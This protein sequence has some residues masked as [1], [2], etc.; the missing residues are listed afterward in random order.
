[1]NK[2][3]FL[4]AIH[5]FLVGIKSGALTAYGVLRLKKLQQPIIAVFGGAGAYDDGK[6]SRLAQEFGKKCAEKDMSII[7]GGGPG[8]M[9]AANCGAHSARGKNHTLG[10]AV[11]GVDDGFDNEC[12]PIVK[13]DYFFSRKWLLTRYSQAFVLFPGGI[14]TLDEFAEV[15]N[16][17]KLK[18]MD[19][20]PIIFFGTSYWKSLIDWYQHAFDY[21]FI[22]LPPQNAFIVVDDVDEALAVII[23]SIKE[24]T[25]NA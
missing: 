8:I 23:N 18:K 15:L 25:K 24:R 22:E 2:P 10:I 1:M 9:E 14:G 3:S 7:T 13:M 19:K 4:E 16:L 11:R 12:A 20:V 5:M 17:I 6:Y 21:D